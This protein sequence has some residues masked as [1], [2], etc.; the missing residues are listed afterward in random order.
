MQHNTLLISHT[1]LC[2]TNVAMFTNG[3]YLW[4]C[5][6][7]KPN[8]EQECVVDAH[9]SFY[10][11]LPDGTRGKTVQ[12][13]IQLEC[14][15]QIVWDD[16]KEY[17]SLLELRTHE[18]IDEFIVDKIG[19]YILGKEVSDRD[20]FC[21]DEKIISSW[22]TFIVEMLKCD[23]SELKEKPHSKWQSILSSL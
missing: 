3:F 7:L 5:G 11:K 17:A 12:M 21:I 6:F 2:Q 19:A 23:L 4:S 9:C 22:K 14:E 18:Y 1:E 8:K 10:S 16:I 13:E 20:F 15:T